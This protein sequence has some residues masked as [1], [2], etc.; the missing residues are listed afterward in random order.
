MDYD[1]LDEVVA[2]IWW[3]SR[4]NHPSLHNFIAFINDHHMKFHTFSLATYHSH[5]HI[6]YRKLQIC[7]GIH[8][9][10]PHPQN[11]LT[12][13][14]NT[15]PTSLHPSQYTLPPKNERAQTPFRLKADYWKL[16]EVAHMEATITKHIK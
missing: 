16:D 5:L 6:K 14:S 1:K 13:P 4:G 10:L 9:L 3:T 7:P 2:Q 15:L 12:Q 11:H 8:H